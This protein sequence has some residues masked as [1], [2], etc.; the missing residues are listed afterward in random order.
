MPTNCLSVFGHFVR[1]ALT[2]L[3]KTLL[4]MF[5]NIA[6]S[7]T[8]QIPEFRPS[9]NWYSEKWLPP[10]IW[11]KRNTCKGIPNWEVAYC[12]AENAWEWIQMDNSFLN[13]SRN[14]SLSNLWQVIAHKRVSTTSKL[15]RRAK[16]HYIKTEGNLKTKSL[17]NLHVNQVSTFLLFFHI[18]FHYT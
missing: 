16:Y 6:M 14:F 1:L 12:W 8:Q 7:F 13:T 17:Q 5:I 3:R 15:L 11:C 18:F 2:G 10:A 4:L 9:R